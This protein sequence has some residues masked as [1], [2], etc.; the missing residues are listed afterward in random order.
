MT[1]NL[2][3][4]RLGNAGLV[5]YQEIAYL[6]FYTGYMDPGTT[7][8]VRQAIQAAVWYIANPSNP[9]GANNSWVTTVQTLASA[10]F[11]GINFS[12][13]F[14]LSDPTGTYQEFMVMTPEPG[15]LI[16]FG[17]GLLGIGRQ[18]QKRRKRQRV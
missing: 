5:A 16:L 14:V 4:T 3:G 8:A 7:S 12:N 15:T 11:Y 18:W 13:A 1:G 2:S 17:T 10:N 6:F 9:L